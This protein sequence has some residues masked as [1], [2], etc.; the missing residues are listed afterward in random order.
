[1]TTKTLYVMVGL[2]RSGKS[3]FAQNNT[4]TTPIANPDSIRKAMGHVYY[5]P[6]EPMVWA[7]TKLMVRSLFLAGHNT[8]CLDA[9]NVSKERRDEW[10]NPL[11][12]D[13]R[14]VCVHTEDSLEKQVE[15][16]KA[17]AVAT[18][19]E[20]LIPVIDSMAKQWDWEGSTKG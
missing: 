3:S 15:I 10:I 14:F 16:C 12:W 4:D 1:M 8:V 18:Q 5:A 2:P 6:I 11:E 19:Q 17:R 7:V 20:Y 9:C 13:T